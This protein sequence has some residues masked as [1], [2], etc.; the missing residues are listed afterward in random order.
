MVTTTT[1]ASVLTVY[2]AGF[3]AHLLG[4]GYSR[5]AATKH[6][7]L[8]GEF[9]GWAAGRGL[10]VEDLATVD[11]GVFFDTRLGGAH[12][13]LRSARSLVPLLGY[14]RQIGVLAPPAPRSP[15]GVIE[16]FFDRYV[17]FLIAERG[18]TSG[19]MVMYVR[20]ARQFAAELVEVHGSLDWHGVRVRDVTDFASRTCAVTG[21]RGHVRSCRR[22]GACCA[23]CNWRHCRTSYW[24]T[25][26]CLL[27]GRVLRRRWVSAG[28]RWRRCCRRATASRR[29]VGAITR[30]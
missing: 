5:S 8:F 18:L 14:L 12:K 30:S 28:Q 23:I 3:C 7:A 27:R 4:L 2:K 17:E 21:C 1:G 16:V 10:R 25:L 26:F 9:A 15:S 29:L 20:V 13:S 19:T 11:A 22:C 24:M 6:R